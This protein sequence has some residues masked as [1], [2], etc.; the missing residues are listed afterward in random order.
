MSKS[1][2]ASGIKHDQGKPNLSLLPASFI[3]GV[4]QVLDFGAKKY[5]AHNWRKGFA[6]S[7]TYSAA[8]RHLT[9]WNEGEQADSESGLSHLKHAA[10][11]LA[12]LIEFE[13]KRLGIDDRFKLDSED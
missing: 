13:E 6:W 9:A 11:N 12:F 1:S 7:R 10:C 2:S 3:V 4:T 5:A 8:L